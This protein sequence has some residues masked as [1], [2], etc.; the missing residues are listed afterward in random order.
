MTQGN[1]L[2]G[3]YFKVLGTAGRQTQVHPWVF[4]KTSVVLYELLD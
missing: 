4:S 1:P 3:L 2:M